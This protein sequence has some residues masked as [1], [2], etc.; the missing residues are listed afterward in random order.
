MKTTVLLFRNE[1]AGWSLSTYKGDTIPTLNFD[2]A[3]EAI[4]HAKKNKWGISRCQ[5][6]D[7]PTRAA[8]IRHAKESVSELR[9][10]GCGYMFSQFDPK[11]NTWRESRPMDYAQA[12]TASSQALIDAAREFLGWTPIQYDGGRWTNYV[13]FDA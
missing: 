12:V 13:R 1:S 3:K 7:N 5:R 4:A 6:C 10:M 9:V 2:T 11:V 8:A